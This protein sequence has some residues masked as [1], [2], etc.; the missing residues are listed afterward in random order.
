MYQLVEFQTVDAFHFYHNSDDKEGGNTPGANISDHG[1]LS[2]SL[3]SSVKKHDYT[4]FETLH[5]YCYCVSEDQLY[6]L[7]EQYHCSIQLVLKNTLKQC[8]TLHHLSTER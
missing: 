7:K 1:E 6:F 3:I 5:S 4:R 2:A 8:D